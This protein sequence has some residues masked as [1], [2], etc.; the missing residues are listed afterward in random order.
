[1]ANPSPSDWRSARASWAEATNPPQPAARASAPRRSTWVKD[2]SGNPHFLQVGIREAGQ[3]GDRQH[4]RLSGGLAG[5]L[6]GG[7]QHLAA[8]GGVHGQHADAQFGGRTHRRGDGVGD[9]VIF[10]VEKH[11]PAGGDQVADDLRPLGREQLFSDLVSGCGV[12]D[13]L[14]DLAGLR[15]A[16]DIERHNEPVFDVH[17]LNFTVLRQ[18]RERL[19]LAYVLRYHRGLDDLQLDSIYAVVAHVEHLGRAIGQVEDPVLRHRPAIVDA[20]DD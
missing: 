7:L 11:L 9:V 12:V 16:R 14:D 6:D 8:A 10:Q 1:M 15:G 17:R 4:H 2:V 19:L 5:G 18:C 20:D 3:H 13:G